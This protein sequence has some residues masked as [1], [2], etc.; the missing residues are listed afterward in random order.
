MS[1]YL[2]IARSA[3]ALAASAKRA[4][5][6]VHVIDCFADEDTKSLSESVHQ[7]QYHCEG[8]ALDSLLGHTR[9][10]VSHHPG[11]KI[12]VG[13]G[14]ETNPDLIDE[15]SDIVPVLSNSKNTIVSLKD[16]VSFSEILD[17]ASIKYPEISLTRPI[18]SKKWLIKRV[19]GIG[20]G[21]VQWLEYNSSDK[22]SNFYYQQYVSG[23]VSS[24]VFLANG[25]HAKIVGFN[26]QI[27]SS[28]FFEMPFLFQGAVRVDDTIEHH[29]HDIDEIINA[30]TEETGL[31]G[32]CGLDY[33]VDDTGDIYVLEVNP[34]PPSTFELH[35][36]GQSLFNAHLTCFDGR[37][38]DYKCENSENLQ[39]YAILYS[40]QDVRISNKINW[41]GYVKDR[42]SAGSEIP[43]R[44]PVCTVHAEENS[45]DKVKT[46]LFNRLD[47]IESIIATMQNAA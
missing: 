2:I 46:L 13:S 18:D 4:G 42:P 9:D 41:P 40:T 7:L 14:F 47:Q 11:V 36:S 31:T 15:L 27:Q 10:I 32:L 34:R 1:D 8:F 25:T 37:L 21:H 44:F 12:V 17:R 28:Q 6:N 43:A 30:I 26:Q 45:I 38:I 29:K 24:V 3:R 23:I 33:I 35:E 20:G 5:Y 22:G 19:A 39:G 16:P